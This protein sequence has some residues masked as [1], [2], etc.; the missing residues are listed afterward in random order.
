MEKITIPISGMH[1]A[2]CA[3]N[4]ERKLKKLNGV[5]NA[6]ANY[7]TNRAIVEY[8]EGTIG[9][10]KFKETIEALGYRADIPGEAPEK[11]KGRLYLHI[12]GMDS[13]H[14]A[15]IVEKALRK[16]GGV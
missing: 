12:V 15:G 11:G 7:A 10:G 13:L 1:C 16:T 9:P 2:T 6:N 5:K 3:I 14:C 4:I 8:D